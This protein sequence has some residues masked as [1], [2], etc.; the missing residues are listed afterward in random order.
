V[1]LSWKRKPDFVLALGVDDRVETVQHAFLLEVW[2]ADLVVMGESAR[3]A[4]VAAVQQLGAGAGRARVQLYLDQKERRLILLSPGG[5]PQATLNLSGKRPPL[6]TGVRL[7]NR[8][9]DVRLERLRITR[10]NGA[11]PREVREDQARVHR[12]DGSVVYGRLAAFD[13]QSKEFTVRDDAAETVVKHDAIAD[14]FLSPAR[15]AG[16]APA[17]AVAG[18]PGRTLRLVYRDGARFRGAP[19]PLPGPAPT[20]AAP[21]GKTRCACRWPTCAG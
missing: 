6:R 18:T 4:D 13:P 20:A 17:D 10:W 21:P 11:A 3:D 9:G 14:V 8:V 15:S 12:T 16:E 19:T 7:T 5:L 1:E 2:D